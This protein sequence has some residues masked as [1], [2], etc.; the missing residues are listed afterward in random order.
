MIAEVDKAGGGVA[1]G[2]LFAGISGGVPDGFGTGNAA[3]PGDGDGTAVVDVPAGSTPGALASLTRRFGHGS[4]LAALFTRDVDVRQFGDGELREHLRVLRGAQSRLYAL[5]AAAVAEL[6]RRRGAERAADVLREDTKQARGSARRDVEFAERL[7]ALPATAGALGSGTITERQAR[8]IAEAAA[9]GPI[10]EA[11]LVAAAA[12]ES[13]DLFGRTLRDHV[14]ERSRDDLEERRRRQRAQRRARVK[15]QSDGMYELFARF[16]PIAG[17]R[18][19]AA[20]AVAARRLWN[21]EDAKS[22]PT[23]QQR[24]A[25]ALEGLIAGSGGRAGGGSGVR[26]GR[27]R[28][29]QSPRNPHC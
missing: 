1:A 15:K 19:E 24:L 3:L 8:M 17:S 22:R 16:D 5:D 29:R 25:D 7:S 21:N 23:P 6:T 12:T 9:A 11:L 2:A 14:N 13:E 20:I 10:D 28:A 18:I 4:P 27:R 26:P